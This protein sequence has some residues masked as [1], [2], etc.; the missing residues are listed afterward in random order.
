MTGFDYAVLAVLGLSAVIGIWRGLLRE[1]FALAAWIAA[2]VAAVL[3]AGE[4]AALLPANFATP[5]VR[6]VIAVA[7][8]F[9]AVLMA[10]SLGGLL[11]SRLARAVG[12]SL[13]DRTLGAVFGV[14][15]GALILLVL[16]L[17][18]GL[19]ALPGE[20]FWRHAKLSAPLETAAIA[21]K[22]YLPREVAER[23][24]FER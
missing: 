23:V 22:P 1:V 4:A 16:V 9:V 24:R 3:F 6:S 2:T 13:A 12:L 10:V 8:L 21:V 20:P 14:A 7:V 11:A 19:T 17:A 5:L 15:R 18:A